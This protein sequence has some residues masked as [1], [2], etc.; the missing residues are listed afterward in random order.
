MDESALDAMRPLSSRRNPLGVK[1]TTTQRNKLKRKRLADREATEKNMQKARRHTPRPL[2]SL[3][4]SLPKRKRAR[5]DRETEKICKG[6]EPLLCLCLGRCCCCCSPTTTA[7][8]SVSLRAGPAHRARARQDDPEG[9]DAHGAYR[10]ASRP[11]L[12]V[13]Y[14]A[15]GSFLF[16]APTGAHARVCFCSPPLAIYTS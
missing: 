13:V 4:L 15:E 16:R 2:L 8:L 1:L 14:R 7:F 12:V 3:S 6:G 9:S 5:A 10:A 11:R